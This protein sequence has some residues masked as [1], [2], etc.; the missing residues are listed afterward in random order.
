M[1]LLYL[2]FICIRFLMIM[3]TSTMTG[4]LPAVVVRHPEGGNPRLTSV[5]VVF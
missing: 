1:G 5:V 2:W 3:H 4:V